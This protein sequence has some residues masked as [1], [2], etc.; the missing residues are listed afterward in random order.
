M[1]KTLTAALALFTLAST[2]FAGPISAQDDELP[3][4]KDVADGS[5]RWLRSVQN[6][7]D[8]SY[9]GDVIG[10]A[11][12]L[13]ALH[14]SPR[15]YV[16]ADGPF[17]AKALDYLVAHQNED[18]SI[19]VEGAEA[20]DLE[21][22]RTAAAA[23]S[24]HADKT[25]A[26]ALGKAA[27]WLASKDV[28]APT[29]DR[30]EIPEDDAEAKKLALKIVAGRSEDG[31]WSGP[32]GEVIETA[33]RVTALGELRSKL[34][35]ASDGD[36]KP[37][38]PLPESTPATDEERR[39]A[40]LKGARFLLAAGD[41]ARWGSPDRADAGLTAMAVGGLQAVPE[42]RPSDIQDA[43]DSA[44]KWL[45][46]LQ[47]DDG[48][49][50]QGRVVNYVTSAS[51]MALAGD[52]EYADTV[53]KARAF[54]ID[55]QADEGEGYSEGDI[56]YG[57][58][59][60]GGDERPDLSNLQ[61]ALEALVASGSGKDDREIKLALKYLERCQNRSESN[62]VEVT[63]DGIVIKSGDDGGAGYAPGESKAG[64]IELDD[65]TRVPRSYGSMSYALL[66]GF[67]F[68]GLTKDDPRVAALWKWLRENYT[69]D[70]N[71]GFPR[72]GDPVAPYQGL[73]YYYNT[74]AKALDA[75]GSE[76]IVTPDGVAHD[77][78]SELAG[79]LVALQSKADGSWVN[80]N[81]PRWWEGNPVL[82][83]SYALQA[84]AA[85]RPSSE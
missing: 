23:L 7:E 55:L 43:I 73:F 47:R 70:V 61:M 63:R 38:T 24:V 45:N 57:G 16:R 29:M 11:W 79:K 26:A 37:V 62:D 85:T 6:P 78:R 82:A 54:L 12:V 68:A 4:L 9:G 2:G 32:A 74:M 60:Y 1:L 64:L 59:G 22:T 42:P 39:A 58:I 19:T 66:K 8:G 52:R 27:G 83:T 28:D 72:G 44:K 18:G 41:G 5:V 17:M 76:E 3:D 69:L 36:A 67:A 53:K 15:T 65:G 31:T 46:S 51:V 50:H 20:S 81:A 34:K 75:F 77:W 14:E 30:I 80:V 48:S 84:L 71:P 56:Y 35:P 25:T 13:Y 40:V 21:Q 10:T 49:I 33:K